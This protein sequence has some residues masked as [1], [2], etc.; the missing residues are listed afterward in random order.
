MRTYA[1]IPGGG[2][3]PWDWHVSAGSPRE[4]LCIDVDEI[5]GGHMVAKGNPAALAGRLD[6]YGLTVLGEGRDCG[7]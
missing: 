7:W 6:A 5:D 4:R 3:D 1:L 2:G